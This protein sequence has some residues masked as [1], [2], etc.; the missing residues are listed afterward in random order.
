MLL[1]PGLADKLVSDA[2]ATTSKEYHSILEVPDW[3]TSCCLINHVKI[4][5]SYMFKLDTSLYICPHLGGGFYSI[6]TLGPRKSDVISL[7][8]RAE[9]SQ[10]NF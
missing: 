7:I 1:S 6:N 8:S 5:T 9:L 3:S 2:E 10:D 4:R